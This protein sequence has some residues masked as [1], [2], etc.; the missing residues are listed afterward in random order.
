MSCRCCY[1]ADRQGVGLDAR[2]MT[3]SPAARVMPGGSGL[4]SPI[5]MEPKVRQRRVVQH[6]FAYL[7][8]ALYHPP[9]YRFLEMRKSWERGIFSS[10]CQ[11]V[12]PGACLVADRRSVSSPPF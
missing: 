1:F 11:A 7:D 9:V 10:D 12:K 2:V 6:G 8:I 4:G 3:E 5:D